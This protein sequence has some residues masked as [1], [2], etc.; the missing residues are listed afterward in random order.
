MKKLILT[1]FAL[2][3]LVFTSCNS[4]DDTSIEQLATCTDGI[5]NGLETGVDC[6]GPCAACPGDG[7]GNG[8]GAV[9]DE[10]LAGLI[11][12]DLTLTN[13]VIWE[14]NGKVVVGNGVTL[15]I[16][17]GTIIKGGEGTGSLASALIVARG[18][19]ID[20]R[21]TA[22]QPIIFTSVNDNIQI[23]QL[24]GT[25]LDENDRGLWGG[26]I[27]LGYAPSSFEGDSEISQIEGIPADDDFGR[28]GGSDPEDNSGF[29]EYVSIRHGGAL[30]GSGNEINGLTLG[31]VGRGTTIN[32][33]EIVGN[34]DDGVEW[35]GG[36]V[37]SSNIVVFAGGD[38]GLDIDQA[39]SGTITNALVIQGNI[40]D[41]ALE[42]DGPE[43]T[44][45]G[46][47]IIDGLTIIGDP[48]APDG[49]I[50]DFRD[51]AMGTIKNVFIKG[52]GPAQDVEL[53]DAGSAGNYNSGSLVFDAWE[54]VLPEGVSN[55][56]DIFNDTTTSTTLKADTANFATA[57][58][59]GE[60][61]VG[62]DL[63]VFDWT[64]AKMRGAF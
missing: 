13:D 36:N 28:Y 9:V 42:I 45:Q 6:G 35:F 26:V 4:D 12:Q 61:T 24:A 59:D 27:I 19:M 32:H 11:A 49:E 30:I 58:N 14:L 2:S 16:E 51:G 31:G 64:F 17:P 39:Y 47:F 43:G 34:V 50:A 41:H 20:A 8:G 21:G 46:A 29:L 62:A 48:T 56:A 25:N 7:G 33:I 5:Q 53:D 44:L 38:D 10:D 22:E 55:V 40:S 37:N 60:E 18:G 52:F 57:I 1:A 23:G 54:I 15:T 63:S 3:A